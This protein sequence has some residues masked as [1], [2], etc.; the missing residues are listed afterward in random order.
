M[1]PTD[2]AN[3]RPSDWTEAERHLPGVRRE[4]QRL[5][6]RAQTRPVRLFVVTALLAAAAL[7]YKETRNPPHE[8]VVVIRVTENT[9]VTR[10]DPL[11]V[12]QLDEYLGSVA[13]SNK[14][15]EKIIDAHDLYPIRR[16]RERSTASTVC[17]RACRWS[18][19]TTSS[20]STTR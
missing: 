4:L 7:Y 3:H 12:R 6:R 8:A 14:Q 19:T 10:A 5:K 9:S 18:C 20:P 17:A 16:T 13:L 2:D 11:A 1:P 15:L